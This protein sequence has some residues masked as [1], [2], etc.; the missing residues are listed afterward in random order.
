M[1]AFKKGQKK[2]NKNNKNNLLYYLALSKDYKSIAE[3]TIETVHQ[4]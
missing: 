3:V 4:H 1:I 2:R